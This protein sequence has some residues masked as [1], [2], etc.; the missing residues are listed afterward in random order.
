MDL[1]QPPLSSKGQ[2]QTV[3]DQG[4]KG[5]QRQGRSSQATI[6]QLWGSD[7]VPSQGIKIMTQASYRPKGKGI[8]LMLLS[9]MNALNL[10]SLE[11]FLVLLPHL[12]AP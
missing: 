8:F 7:L 2:V 5:R 9:E 10:N 11:P 4:R 3:A 6:A 1:T 12:T